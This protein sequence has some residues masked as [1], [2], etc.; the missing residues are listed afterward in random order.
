MKNNLVALSIF[1]LG[2]C[3]VIGSWVISSGLGVKA[4]VSRIQSVQQHQ[5]LTQSE[6]VNYLGIS[7]EAIQKLTE[8]PDDVDTTS[9]LP[10]IKIG[11]KFYYPKSAIDKWLLNVDLTTITINK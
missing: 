7:K 5:L 9:G 1:F 3:I 6:L 10:Y 11:E 2:L 4:N 8:L